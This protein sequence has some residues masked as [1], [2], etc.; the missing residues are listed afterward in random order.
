MSAYSAATSFEGPPIS[1][2][3]VSIAASE[4]EPEGSVTEPEFA[5]RLVR[6]RVQYERMP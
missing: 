5:V 3:P 2:V 6:G 4:D 1:V